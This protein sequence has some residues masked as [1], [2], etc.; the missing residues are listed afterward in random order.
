[1]ASQGRREWGCQPVI[2]DGTRYPSIGAAAAVI[3]VSRLT[4]SN[5]LRGGA[6]G[7]Q[8]DT[9]TGL[10]ARAGQSTVNH[11]GGLPRRPVI[12]KG[13]RYPS[14]IAAAAA[15]GVSSTAIRYRLASRASGCQDAPAADTLPTVA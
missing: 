8:F 2:A 13:T 12:V 11:K 4:I 10:S 6:S 9:P 1:M 14:L 7:Y 3:G 15:E 5:R